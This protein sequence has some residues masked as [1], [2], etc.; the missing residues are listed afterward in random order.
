MTRV[1]LICAVLLSMAAQAHAQLPPVAAPI[2]HARNSSG[3]FAMSVD[4]NRQTLS[5]IKL[6]VNQNTH[7]VGA[8]Q[9]DD[10]NQN[11]LFVANARSAGTSYI[12]VYSFVTNT[13]TTFTQRNGQFNG[14]VPG[15]DGSLYSY[16]GNNV[17]NINRMGGITTLRAN[18]PGT[19]SAIGLDVITTN[20]LL[21][22][23]NG[24]L[25][26]LSQNGR[27][28]STVQTGLGNVRS[29]DSSASTGNYVIT[30]TASPQLR[31][32]NRLGA[33]VSFFVLANITTAWVDQV[34]G[35]IWMTELYKM[36]QLSAALIVLST[37]QWAN[38]NLAFLSFMRYGW[39]VISGR[40][41]L[42]PGVP[43]L[44][45]FYFRNMPG[46][47]Y[48][49]AL[50]LATRPGILVGR[51]RRINLAL[52]ALFFAVVVNGLFVSNFSGILNA[53]GG[54]MATMTIPRGIPPGLLIYCAVI[55][56][57]GNQLEV[58][59]TFPM[60]C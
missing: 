28:L 1:I 60:M 52:D 56:I 10:D 49:A 8:V 14:L 16:D 57:L 20:L 11:L 39:R 59:H 30:T 43:F 36:F 13:V 44:L 33:L 50:A 19:I 35:H 29:V 26:A 15:Q 51:G 22:S 9:M 41:V 42:T 48:I 17:L 38:P 53:N 3:T 58:S 40:G 37:W 21:G 2:V 25:W 34:T 55:A 23:I 24:T 18:L 32:L 47:A 5:T 27:T 7:A 4:L 6:G 31:V 45:S 54:A 46:A 12:G